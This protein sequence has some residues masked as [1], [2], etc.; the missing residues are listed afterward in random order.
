MKGTRVR[1]R[2]LR[3]KRTEMGRYVCHGDVQPSDFRW[4]RYMRPAAT[5]TLT[6]APG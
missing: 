6:T 2:L 1:N 3:K 5:K 4:C